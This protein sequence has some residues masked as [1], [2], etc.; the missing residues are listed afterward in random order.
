ML[1]AP[2]TRGV[3]TWMK[4]IYDH[5]A[6]PGEYLDREEIGAPQDIHFVSGDSTSMSAASRSVGP[7]IEL[8]F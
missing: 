8:M 6:P 7:T 4:D 1:P 2:L 5:G 3:S